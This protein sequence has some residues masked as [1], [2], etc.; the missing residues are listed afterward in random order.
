MARGEK[1]WYAVYTHT[2]QENKVKTNIERMVES[3]DLRDK[4]FRVVVPVEEETKFVSG[5]KRTVKKKVFP[6]YVFVEMVMD[7]RAWYLLRNT[8]GVTGFVGS[9]AAPTPLPRE[10]VD[11]ILRAIGGEGL[12]RQ[13]AWQVSEVV[14]VLT[15]P[16]A[17]FTGTIQS[18]DE[19]REKATVLISIFGRDT[20]VE[21]DFSHIERI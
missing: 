5:K 10:E 3:A 19:N 17:E 21:L 1:Q 13:P 15:G 18:I 20:P 12:R 8:S 2:G 16:F 7:D 9:D 6:G 11:S 14:R 4:V